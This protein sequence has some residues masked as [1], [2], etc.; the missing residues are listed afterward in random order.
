MMGIILPVHYFTLA[1]FC[2]WTRLPQ[3]ELPIFAYAAD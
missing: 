3:D 1:F 2:W